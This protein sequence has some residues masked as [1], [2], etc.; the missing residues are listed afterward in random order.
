MA[1]FTVLEISDILGK[2]VNELVSFLQSPP[3]AMDI[4]RMVAEVN[5]SIDKRTGLTDLLYGITSTQMRSAAEAQVRDQN[6]SVRP[7]DMANSCEDWISESCMKE[8]EAARWLLGGQDIA[9]VVGP[10]AAKVWEEQILTQDVDSV[11]RDFTFR[12]ESGSSRKPNKNA[13]V[14]QLKELGAVIAP[15]LQQFAMTGNPGPW[16]AYVDQL[17]KAMEFDA[18]EFIV[19]PPPPPPAPE[20]Q[21]PGPE[22]I[23]AQAKAQEADMKMQV[24]QHRMEM[25]HQKAM[26]QMGMDQ[27]KHDQEMSQMKEKGAL[28]LALKR[29]LLRGRATE[30]KR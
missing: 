22:E 13:R 26:Q 1:P 30:V 24:E 16:N 15:V 6:V 23:A 12:I 25:D 19:Q 17:G 9:P 3:F 2:N 21:G 7:D 4:W 18:T 8:I 27:E 5:A 10:L 14:Q 11:I 20:Q 28:E 29:S